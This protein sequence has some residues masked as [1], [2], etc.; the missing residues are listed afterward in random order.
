PAKVRIVRLP[1]LP[2][3]G[4]F[5]DFLERVGDGV[6]A[7]EALRE[8][9][10]KAESSSPTKGLSRA[11]ITPI[12][13]D[14][15]ETPPRND[16]IAPGLSGRGLVTLYVAPP[17]CGKTTFMG[18]LLGEAV[19]GGEFIP[20]PITGRILIVT[21]EPVQLLHRR[22]H[23][24]GLGDRALYLT[25]AET[26]RTRWPDLCAMIAEEVASGGYEIVAV[27][28]VGAFWS[29]EDENSAP[30]LTAAMG[31]ARQIAEAGAALILVHHSRKGAGEDV[32]GAS[33]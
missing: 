30:E 10:G 17:K 13:M 26:R 33:R 32:V 1:D 21:E 23:E 22:H 28:T 25:R 3:K 5:A 8:L 12:R 24:R 4:D 16:Y 6:D 20:E 31:A 7:A 15:I 9:A 11:S 14:Q 27:D 19:T 2:A 18:Q 29:V